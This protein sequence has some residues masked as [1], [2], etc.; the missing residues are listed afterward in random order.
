MHRIRLRDPW[1][2]SLNVESGAIVYTRNFHRPTG[3][4]DRTL[5]LGVALL[6][7][8]LER[9]GTKL[10]VTVNGRELL[11]QG[12]ATDDPIRPGL[13]FHLDDLKAYNTLQ[14]GISPATGMIG[15][16]GSNCDPTSIP[17]FGSF[18]IESVELQIE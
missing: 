17:T 10:V 14:L 3:T 5:V 13:R 18:V 12:Q 1:T 8:A 11:P 16:S 6:P 4:E 15:S 9:A 7:Q 2:A